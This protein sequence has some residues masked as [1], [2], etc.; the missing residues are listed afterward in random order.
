MKLGKI[1]TGLMACHVTG[2]APKICLTFNS[3]ESKQWYN[4]IK[5]AGAQT[6]ISNAI[7][8]LRPPA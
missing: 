6:W 4:G 2:H 1:F 5:E 8:G 3:M 7:L